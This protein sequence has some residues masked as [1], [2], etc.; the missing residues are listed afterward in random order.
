MA[1]DSANWTYYGGTRGT[2][3]TT[4]E[5][6]GNTNTNVTVNVMV[7]TNAQLSAALNNAAAGDTI[8]LIAGTFE[9]P[10]TKANISLKGMTGNAAD[11]K[12]ANNI[13]FASNAGSNGAIVR[14]MNFENLSFTTFV[15]VRNDSGS[16]ETSGVL[17]TFKNVVF[18]KGVHSSDG[19][20]RAQ[21]AYFEDCVFYPATRSSITNELLHFGA[22]EGTATR[23]KNCTFKATNFDGSELD[24]DGKTKIQ[25]GGANGNHSK[26]ITFEG[27]TFEKGVELSAWV[28]VKYIDCDFKNANGINCQDGWEITID[29]ATNNTLATPL[30]ASDI[31]TITD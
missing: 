15:H 19:A 6:N 7:G 30:A 20:S 13:A 12:L 4:F 18:E 27:C 14:K 23:F 9:L 5:A 10:S 2:N 17:S 28:A 11:V 16:S 29:N 1:G 25:I 21:G 3:V 22:T 31:I 8:Y 24:G 26:L